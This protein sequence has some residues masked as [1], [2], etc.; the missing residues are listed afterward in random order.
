VYRLLLQKDPGQG[1][2]RTGVE[3]T[4]SEV[5]ADLWA[6]H[7]PHLKEDQ[8]RNGM[9]KAAHYGFPEKEGED[10]TTDGSKLK[11]AFSRAEMKQSKHQE[12]SGPQAGTVQL[13]IACLSSNLNLAAEVK[14]GDEKKRDQKERDRDRSMLL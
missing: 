5:V 1:A 2:E 14:E 8:R 11:S 3:E 4:W 6:K 13:I 12:P 9:S 7:L 10:S